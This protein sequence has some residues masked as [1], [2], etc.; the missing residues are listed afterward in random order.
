MNARISDLLRRHREASDAGLSLIEVVIAMMVFAIISTGVAYSLVATLHTAKDGKGREVALNL[1]AQEIDSSRAVDDI[2]ALTSSS[3]TATVPGDAT[4]YTVSRAVDWVTS[5]GTLA[6]CGAGS[7]NLQ[8]KEVN[9]TVTWPGMV[10][11]NPVRA[12]TI[13]APQTTIN[14]PTLGTILVSVKNAAGAGVPG[15]TIATSPPTGTSTPV[16]DA[17]GCSYILKVPPGS[18][19]VNAAL[20]GY[21]DVAQDPNPTSPTLTV[22]AGSVTPASFSMDES[23]DLTVNYASN[24]SGTPNLATDFVTTF[25]STIG[26]DDQL[27]IS[28][29]SSS[30][31]KKYVYPLYPFASYT[32]NAGGYSPATQA[33]A[34]CLDVDPTQ[35]PDGTVGGVALTAPAAPTA[36]FVAGGSASVDVPMGVV[37]LTVSSNNRYYTA[38]SVTPPSGTGD[39]GCSP[40]VT[41]HFGSITPSSTKVT[42]ALPFGSYTFKSGKTASSLSSLAASKL[43]LQAGSRGEISSSGVVTFDPRKPA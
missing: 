26:G 13:V 5:N 37:T 30:S 41:Y 9:V 43:A 16:T 40:S 32:I 28:A 12:D 36:A 33:S 6:N 18:Y 17:D 2:F 20:A 35:W 22:T 1:A 4:V 42:I 15:V 7:G 31:G 38:T 25:S 21:L 14:D 3:H 34:G 8:F 11:S 23:G 10:G 29:A 39:P 24:Y 27:P 19:T